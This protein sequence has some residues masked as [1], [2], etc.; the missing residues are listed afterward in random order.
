MALTTRII[1]AEHYSLM[2]QG[3]ALML[4]KAPDIEVVGEAATGIEAIEKAADLQPDVVLLD[5]GLPDMDGTAVTRA[6]REQYPAVQVLAL[7]STARG[8]DERTILDVVQAGAHGYVALDTTGEELAGYIKK[9]AAGQ[10]AFSSA[11]IVQLVDSLGQSGRV[12]AAKGVKSQELLTGREKEVLRLVCQ[13]YP[14]KEIAPSMA[15]SENTVRAHVRSLMQKLEFNNRTQL[16]VYGMR[17][18]Y[19]TPTSESEGRTAGRN[20]SDRD[21]SR[22]RTSAS[23]GSA[24]V[25]PR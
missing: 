6:I 10:T 13:G 20:G 9:V 16:A 14:N 3:L 25:P 21:A 15:V 17:N 18:G 1:I 7:S 24:P 2:R 23:S 11:L 4:A 5:C 8:Q 19:A 12:A 22:Y